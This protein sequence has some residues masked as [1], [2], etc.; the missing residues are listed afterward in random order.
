MEGAKFGVPTVLLDASYGAVKGDYQFRWIF[1]SEDYG[2]ADLMD[3]SHFASGNESLERIVA[4]VQTDYAALSVRTFEYCARN[5]SISS[6]CEK[7]L[8][9]VE[10]ASFRYGDFSPGIMQKGL[11]RQIYERVR[12]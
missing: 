8:A 11:I 7:F 5:H 6:V 12:K 10:V 1:E 4:D 2:L 3:G 9:A